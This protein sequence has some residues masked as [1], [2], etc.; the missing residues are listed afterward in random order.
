[1]FIHY[2]HLLHFSYMFRRYIH[3]RQGEIFL[4]FIQTIYCYIAIS[5]RFNS[6]HTVNF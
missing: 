5:Y 1:M 4:P 2:I 3:H 6:S